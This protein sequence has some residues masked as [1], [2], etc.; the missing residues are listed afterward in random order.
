MENGISVH[1]TS[2]KAR[3]LEQ[4]DDPTD[5]FFKKKIFSMLTT[6]EFFIMMLIMRGL[7]EIATAVPAVKAR[8]LPK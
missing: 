4:L 8:L 2:V 3:P 7:R 5:F 1:I 6:Q